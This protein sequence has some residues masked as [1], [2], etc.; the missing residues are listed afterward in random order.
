VTNLGTISGLQKAAGGLLT[1]DLG[2]TSMEDWAFTF[3]SP[4]SE[5]IVMV[6]TNGGNFSTLANGN[7]AVTKETLSL[8][9]AVHNDTVYEFTRA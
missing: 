2:K 5:N 4:R 1:L 8:L 9:S 6:K 7:E 3:K